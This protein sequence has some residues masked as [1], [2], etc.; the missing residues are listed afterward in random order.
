MLQCPRLQEELVP[1]I[2]HLSQQ[3]RNGLQ[4]ATETHATEGAYLVKASYRP[5]WVPEHLAT[6]NGGLQA[7]GYPGGTAG[8]GQENTPLGNPDIWIP[9]VQNPVERP[10]RG[11]D[12]ARAEENT[13]EGEEGTEEKTEQEDTEAGERW[14]KGPHEEQS[15]PEQLTPGENLDSGQGS[16][17][18]PPRPWRGVAPAGTVL[19]TKQDKRFGGEG[20]GREREEKG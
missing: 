16:P 15:R 13:E 11:E 4:E 3:T 19:L 8:A 10:R 6:D 17:E 20:G 5:L 9:I 18:T 12:H 2:I 7:A 1:R 14:S